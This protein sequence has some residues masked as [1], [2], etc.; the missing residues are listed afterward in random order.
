MTKFRTLIGPHV[1][2]G[3]VDVAEV[4]VIAGKNVFSDYRII[5]AMS[6]LYSCVLVYVCIANVHAA[7]SYFAEN[8]PA[9]DQCD[10]EKCHEGPKSA[11]E[12]INVIITFTNA[13]GN[14]NLQ[15]KFRLTV[16]SML[17]HATVPL[18]IQIIGDAES[19]SIASSILKESSAKSK[20]TYEVS[21]HF[22]VKH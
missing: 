6:L 15:R 16:S 7:D 2:H 18:R 3:S 13:K 14:T 1:C 10:G 4:V 22:E 9:P 11:P 8:A 5:T 20:T 12:E 19:Q 21:L 17:Q